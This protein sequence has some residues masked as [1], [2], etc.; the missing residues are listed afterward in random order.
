M[1]EK[2]QLGFD[3]FKEGGNLFISGSGG[4]GKT[5]LI[6]V[7]IDECSKTNIK[8]GVT[9]STGI[10]ATHIKGTTIH[11]FLK[12]GIG[13]INV[14]KIYTK[15][16]K[17]SA[18]YRK[19]SQLQL[20]IID[21]ISMINKTLFD[22]INR[23]LQLINKNDKP[24][25]GIQV[26]L[27]GDFCQLKPVKS[28]LFC[29]E[30][31][32]WNLLNLEIIHLVKGMRQVDTNF[33]NMLFNIRFGNCTNKIYNTLFQHYKNTKDV[34][35]LEGEIKPTILYSNNINVNRINMIE[36]NKLKEKSNKSKVYKI[37]YNKWNYLVEKYLKDNTI[38]EMI[39]LCVNDQIFITYNID[40]SDGIS[41]GTRGIVTDIDWDGGVTVKLIDGR[42]IIIPYQQIPIMDTD[43][44]KKT[45]IILS[46]LPIKLAYSITI[47]RSQGMTIDFL[48]VDLG[49]TIFEYGQF[50]VSLS[51]GVSLERIIITNLCRK[52]VKCHEKVLKF[53]GL[54]TKSMKKKASYVIYNWFIKYCK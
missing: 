51:R 16:I 11:S 46:Y 14:Y 53:Y 38:D 43:K 1:N 20:L 6:N 26:I 8:F 4:C 42:D 52:G 39:E 21:E 17:N 33:K 22:K 15:I 48:S 7:I 3:K 37:S 49:P 19:L 32:V 31:V 2:Q 34:E 23:L 12:L 35:F 54:Y 45:N 40:I 5:F 24:F 10:S 9:S 13:N 50:Y 18:S 28:D 29:F 27:S 41:N 25:G 44:G 47:H 30:S 36:H